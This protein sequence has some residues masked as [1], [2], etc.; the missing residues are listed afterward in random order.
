MKQDM[1][2]FARI[3]FFT[4]VIFLLV[5]LRGQFSIYSGAGLSLLLVFYLLSYV[6]ERKW[7]VGRYWQLGIYCSYWFLAGTFCSLVLAGNP[8]SLK[9]LVL[10]FGLSFIGS[11]IWCAILP[12]LFR[13]RF[14]KKIR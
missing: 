4:L 5:G 9:L 12:K 8:A 13:H 6:F 7:R 10:Y 2:Y 1:N 11:A 14:S 3:I